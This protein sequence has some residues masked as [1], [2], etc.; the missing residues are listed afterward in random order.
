MKD[1]LSSIPSELR[2]QNR[3]IV[4]KREGEK[5]EPYNPRK[6]S[7]HANIKV[8]ETWA[9]FAFAKV[10]VVGGKV[11]GLGYAFKRDEPYVVT[12]LDHCMV[13]GQPTSDAA[14]IVRRMDSYTEL[15][16]SGEGLHIVCRGE[17]PTDRCRRGG[18]EIYDDHFIYLTG[19]IWGGR[20]TIEDRQEALDWLCQETFGE[21]K[22]EASPASVSD[23]VLGSDREPPEDKLR[24]LLEDKEFTLLWEHRKKSIPSLSEYDFRLACCAIEANWSDQETADLLLTFRE[25]YGD[26]EDRAKGLREDYIPRTIAKAKARSGDTKVLSLLP[27]KV[28]KVKQY[29]DQESQISLVLDNGREI[30]MGTTDRYVSAKYAQSR[31]IECQLGLSLKALKRWNEIILALQPL[32]ELVPT[33]TREDDARSYMD[34]YIS[35]RLS[36]P[37]AETEDDLKR[38]FGSGL[39]GI[40]ANS[41]GRVYLRL[42]DTT[43]YV[44]VHTGMP[45]INTR[46]VSRD[47]IR[48]GFESYKLSI[49]EE[50]KR[51][52]IRIWVSKPG[53][54]DADEGGD[55]SDTT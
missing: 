1:N 41:K 11:D 17:K 18:V 33:T 12:D 14:E 36:L 10:L 31:L 40:A 44:R 30:D 16:Q 24:D 51:R 15:S 34:D 47:L 28:V 23:L 4:W 19:N 48:L 46:T 7:Q 29:G 43:R 21:G 53:F 8:P 42:S 25:A 38:L 32:M 37:N 13:D 20:K 26:K 45:N 27:F 52:Q 35:G 49:T 9:D 50:G 3:W 55:A 39:H 2:H 6:L 5:K 54:I 22:S